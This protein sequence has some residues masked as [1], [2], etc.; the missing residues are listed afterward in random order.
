MQGPCLI[1]N[2]LT[3]DNTFGPSAHFCA[4]PGSTQQTKGLAARHALAQW[5]G[6]SVLLGLKSTVP[7]KTIA[8]RML[9]LCQQTDG[10]AAGIACFFR[11]VY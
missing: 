10:L 8:H 11:D 7:A 2:L 9:R 3:C 5:L 6:C 4:A 1:E